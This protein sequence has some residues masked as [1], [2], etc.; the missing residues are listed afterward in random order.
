M[1]P[2]A[3][4]RKRLGAWYTPAEL[5]EHVLDHVLDPLL[6]ARPAGSEISV[7]DPACG[8]G[9]FLRAAGARITAAGHVASLHGVDID[10]AAL[11]VARTES[12]GGVKLT[13]ADALTFDWGRRSYDLVVGNPPFLTPLSAVHG[14]RMT[15]RAGGP[16]ADAAAEF[17]ALALRLARPQGGR[18]GLVL[19]LS[20]ISTRDA[21][22]VRDEL[23][24]RGGLDWFWFAPRPVF[25]AEIRTC[26]IG[27]VLGTAP[28]VVR[29]THGKRF[30]DKDPIAPPAEASTWSWL[31]SDQLGVPTLPAVRSAGT[32]ADLATCG[33]D[34]R[35][36]YYGLVGAV[37]E[38]DDGAVAGTAPLVTSGLID[39]G[40]LH[41][42]ERE[43]RFAKRSYLR[44][45]VHL[46]RL[47]A[48]MGQWAKQRLVPKVL[49]ASQTRV[50]EAVADPEG[51]LLPCVPIVSVTPHDP[52]DVWRLA[53]AL[54]G[55]VASA[56]VAARA[57]G[58]GL[59]AHAVR[60]SAPV[61][62]ALPLPAGP[63]NRAV[64]CLRRG[65]VAGCAVAT[66]AAYGL[67]GAA[68]E[69]LLAWWFSASRVPRATPR[70]AR[71]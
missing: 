34:F 10:P 28:P 19:P 11:R 64:Q 65:D 44:P 55:P 51:R 26:A 21:A 5:V 15:G 68:A 42:G 59:S 67:R 7:L 4:H 25:D 22:P 32:L 54:T 70:P 56:W 16:Y 60:I 38:E 36:E 57:G 27:A 29:R 17:V 9:R 30:V 39:P 47:D 71:R 37:E 35:D 58:S 31:V 69:E 45:V 2:D 66:T 13:R 62:A 14:V 52:S 1:T 20:I 33:G 63:V 6:A 12:G 24:R 61:L 23:A 18:I 50:V 3:A 43:T 53:A 8:D 40:S 49:V 46:D 41:W 48:F